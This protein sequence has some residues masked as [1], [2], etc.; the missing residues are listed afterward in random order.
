M[1]RKI[2][3][4]LIL[5][6]GIGLSLHA[7]SIITAPER[8]EPGGLL[9]VVFATQ[10]DPGNLFCYLYSNQSELIVSNEGFEIENSEEIQTWVI[11]LGIPSTLQQGMYTI[12]VETDESRAV[13]QAEISVVSKEFYFEEIALNGTLSDLRS[14]DDPRKLQESLDMLSLL[15]TT[16]TNAHYHFGSLSLP[17][18]EFRETSHY[19]DRR[20]YKYV[21]GGSGKGIHYGI[22]LAAERGTPVHAS[23]GGRV[24]FAAE[25]I[26]TGLSIVVEHLPGVYTLYYHLNSLDVDWGSMVEPGAI[27]GSIGATGLA[28]GNHL[29]WELRVAGVP[30]DP[31]PF[32]SEPLVDK[33]QIFSTI[34][35][36]IREEGR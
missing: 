8:V 26:I 27:I 3:L 17:V 9:Q 6:F 33:S 10:E 4:L 20:Q 32:L 5:G 22:D 11:L 36:K 30:I 34:N 28:T 24:V 2:L 19:G 35:E 23:A 21:D 29:H 7:L 12:V 14:S 25:R 1:N 18:E 15:N 31:K 16:K 13:S